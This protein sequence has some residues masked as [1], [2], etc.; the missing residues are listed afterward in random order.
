ML[1]LSTFYNII[2]HGYNHNVTVS[3]CNW[4]L[5]YALALL[6]CFLCHHEHYTVTAI[7]TIIF[8]YPTCQCGVCV[9]EECTDNVTITPR[10]DCVQQYT[11]FT[12]LATHGHEIGPYYTWNIDTPNG[13]ISPWW[14]FPYRVN[15]LGWYNLTCEAKYTHEYCPEYYAICNDSITFQVFGQ[16][17]ALLREVVFHRASRY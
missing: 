9:C 10:D 17:I 7:V 6:T 16:Y 3:A 5:T 4:L 8:V 13:I 2:K 12:C 15:D 11:D 1:T 14:S